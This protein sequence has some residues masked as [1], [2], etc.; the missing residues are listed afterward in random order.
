[1]FRPQSD[2]C[3]RQAEPGVQVGQG[4]ELHRR[5]AP[6]RLDGVPRPGG[7]SRW[8]VGVPGDD[9]AVHSPAAP[10]H[11]LALSHSLSLRKRKRPIESAVEADPMGRTFLGKPLALLGFSLLGRGAPDDA[12]D[13]AAGGHDDPEPHRSGTHSR[14]PGPDRMELKDS[15]KPVDDRG[16]PC[17]GPCT[18][19]RCIG[20]QVSF[21]D[22]RPV[23]RVESGPSTPPVALAAG[24]TITVFS[25][26]QA[27]GSLS[28][29]RS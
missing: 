27:G 2:P 9:F 29:C 23:R 5:T 3:L 4:V 7:H 18:H 16:K 12:R 15:H 28:D 22:L 19:G 21:A 11:L 14:P 1:M 25:C 26:S 10:L 20:F 24:L 6:R 13:R 8:L 17:S